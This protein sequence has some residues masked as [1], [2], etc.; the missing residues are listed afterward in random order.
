MP[1][2]PSTLPQLNHLHCLHLSTL[3]PS[4]YTVSAGPSTL[5]PSVSPPQPDCLHR[6]S[7]TVYTASICLAASAG[8]STLPQLDRLHGHTRTAYAASICATQLAWESRG[9]GS[10]PSTKW[11]DV[12]GGLRDPRCVPSSKL[13]ALSCL[14]ISVSARQG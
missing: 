2:G 1:P 12:T 3:P 11:P 5:P 6:L 14:S 13:L 7:W 8:L 9:L 4:V 10:D